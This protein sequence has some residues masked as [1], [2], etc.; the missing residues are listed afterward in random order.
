M[1]QLFLGVLVS[2]SLQL[3]LENAP[4]GFRD[5]FTGGGDYLTFYQA[6]EERYLGKWVRTPTTFLE[7]EE[8]EKHVLSL[9]K[10]LT[11][12]KGECHLICSSEY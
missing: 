6:K 12:F 7:L 4:P 2:A 3:H 8:T 11:P 1:S 10:A 9:L 5:L